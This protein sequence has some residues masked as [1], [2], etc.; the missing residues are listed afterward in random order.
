MTK[1]FQALL[2]NHNWE[3]VNPS[4]PIKVV[5]DKWVL[6]IKYNPDGSISR[7]KA[8]HVAKVF[9]IHKDWLYETFNSTEKSST[10]K[11]MLSIIVTHQLVL[12]QIDINNTFLNGYSTNKVYIQPPKGFMDLDKSIHVW[13]LYKALYRLK[14]AQRAWFKRLKMALTTLWNTSYAT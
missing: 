11:L 6:R 12:R 7:Y 2:D 8:R 13:K 5:G 4:H 1:E 9:I 14:Q 3:L 10:I